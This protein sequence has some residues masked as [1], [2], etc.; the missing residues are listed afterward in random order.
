MTTPSSLSRPTGI[1]LRRRLGARLAVTLATPLAR[2]KPR[3][4]RRVLTLLRRGAGPAGYDTAKAAR[5]AVLAVSL[6]CLGPQG[7]LPRSVAVALLCRMSG[8]WPTWCAGVRV[9]PPFGAHAWV[10]ADGVPVDENL[11]AQY[12]RPLMTV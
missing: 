7:C 12:F 10:E 4:L 3:T 8:T 5:D 1:P 6:R 9:M 2:L 11:P